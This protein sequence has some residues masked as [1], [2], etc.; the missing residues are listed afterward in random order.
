LI[1]IFT[2]LGGA[3]LLSLALAVLMAWGWSQTDA[4]STEAQEDLNASATVLPAPTA[5]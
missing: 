3:L 5:N 4:A 1:E 2:R